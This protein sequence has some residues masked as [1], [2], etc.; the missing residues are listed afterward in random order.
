MDELLPMRFKVTRPKNVGEFGKDI[1]LIFKDTNDQMELI[2]YV[3]DFVNQLDFI[4]NCS[5]VSC[6][7]IFFN[8][9]LEFLEA[10]GLLIRLF[11]RKVRLNCNLVSRST[12]AVCSFRFV[13][14]EGWGERMQMFTYTLGNAAFENIQDMKT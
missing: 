12:F 5:G 7:R 14:S 8:R 2:T 9:L 10:I 11:Q 1:V 6:V 13:L 3:F 4:R